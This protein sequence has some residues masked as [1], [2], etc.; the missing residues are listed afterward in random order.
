LRI[1]KKGLEEIA[2]RKTELRPHRVDPSDLCEQFGIA[3]KK[4]AN[5]PNPARLVKKAG[6]YE[7]RIRKT[8]FLDSRDFTQFER[9]LIAHELGHF[10]LEKKFNASPLGESEYWQHEDLCNHFAHVLLVPDTLLQRECASVQRAPKELLQLT[11]KIVFEQRIL[12]ASAAYRLSNYLGNVLLFSIEAKDS[13][14]KVTSSP[15]P[16]RK[17]I[18]RMIS[19][20]SRLGRALD[21]VVRSR[22]PAE[23]GRTDFSEGVLP[24]CRGAETG[25]A[26]R[27]GSSGSK[28]F[29]A[30]TFV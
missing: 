17:E 30:A 23:L 7:I 8:Q 21:G 29:L 28:I 11:T 4:D 3:I 20:A 10:I 13:A 27:A 16:G 22:I 18:G 1:Y 25:L 6:Q 24:S 9:F 5:L 12:W 15:L 19:G 14:F 26:V 2:A